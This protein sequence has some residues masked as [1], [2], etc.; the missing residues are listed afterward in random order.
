MTVA[1]IATAITF[2]VSE[3]I[4]SDSLGLALRTQGWKGYWLDAASTKRMDDDSLI[5]LDPVKLPDAMTATGQGQ[6]WAT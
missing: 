6:W 3:V 1:P 5:V 4:F 2:L